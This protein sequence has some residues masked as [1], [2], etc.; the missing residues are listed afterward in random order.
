MLVRRYLDA[1]R[2][3]SM[4]HGAPEG[5]FETVTEDDVVVFNDFI[6]IDI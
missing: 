5:S 1:W 6:D 4:G 3:G 2:V